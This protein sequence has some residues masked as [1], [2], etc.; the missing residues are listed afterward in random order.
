[1]LAFVTFIP[2]MLIGVLAQ[3][4]GETRVYGVI[5]VIGLFSL[6]LSNYWLTF[7]YRRFVKKMYT[8]AATFR[9]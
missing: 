9:K 2:V 6:L 5:I 8:I 4:L 7:I 3:N 1:V